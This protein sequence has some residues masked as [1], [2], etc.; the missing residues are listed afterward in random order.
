[1]RKNNWFNRL[2]HKAEIESNF[3]E[4]AKVK[5]ILA[6]YES[7][8]YKIEHCHDFIDYFN[9][10]KELWQ[11][12]YRAKCFSPD[13]YGAFRTKD[14]LTM[15]PDEIYLGGLNTHNIPFWEK[16]KDTEAVNTVLNQYRL[17]L[18]RG[19]IIISDYAK[20]KKEELYKLGY[21]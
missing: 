8:L 21:V 12:G 9:I 15:S 20:N 17:L 10:H 16:C 1:M 13:K 4:L 2:F 7:Y 14:I 11:E 18:K 6:S 19:I 3:S 5:S